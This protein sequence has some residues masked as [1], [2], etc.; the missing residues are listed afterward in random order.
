MFWSLRLTSCRHLL[1]LTA[2]LYK[3]NTRNQT[4]TN[5][6]IRFHRNTAIIKLCITQ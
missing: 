6:K 4:L 5:I 1:I 3:K 2:I